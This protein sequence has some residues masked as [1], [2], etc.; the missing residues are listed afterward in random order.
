MPAVP[1]RRPRCGAGHC[2]DSEKSTRHAQAIQPAAALIEIKA[3]RP[4]NYGT[5]Q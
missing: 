1:G 3:I 5:Q 4:Q 2:G